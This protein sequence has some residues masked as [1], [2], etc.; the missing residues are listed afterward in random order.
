MI[1]VA[2]VAAVCIAV[3]VSYRIYDP[4]IWQN[5]VVG[6][7]I[8]QL[9]Q[10]P[11]TQLWSWPTFGAPDIKW[12]WGFSALVW[13]VWERWGV[14]GLFAWRWATA[15]A[16]FALLWA[17][18]RRMGAR[19]FTALWVMVVYSLTWR[20]RSQVRP[21]TL[22]AVLL[23]AQVW[24]LETR[25]QGGRDHTLWLIPVAWAWANVH[26]T[27]FL[28]F[29]VIGIFLLEDLVSRRR[30]P[31]APSARDRGVA[32]P[33][34]APASARGGAT[35]AGGAASGRT[36]GRWRLLWIG[37]AS[38]VISFVN[39]YGWR[40]LWEP[41]DFFLHHRNEPIFQTI[42]ELGPVQW[43]IYWKKGLPFLVAG[44]PL[45]A[46]WHARTRGADRVELLCCAAFTALALP[47]QR[48][49]GLYALVAAPYV[50]RDLEA[51]LASGARERPASPARAKPAPRAAPEPRGAQASRAE[52]TPSGAAAAPARVPWPMRAP[53]AV[54]AALTAL[55]CVAVGWAEWSR[56]EM[57]LGIGFLWNKYPVAACD[58]M[59]AHGVRGRGFNLFG[60]AGYQL[61]RFWPDRTRLP[62]I[63]I[64]QAGS[65]EDR[66]L[67]AWL[68]Q[69]EE[70]WRQLDRKYRF[71]YALIA[72][73]VFE[74]YTLLN[75]LDADST[76][77]L[78]FVDDVM[79]LYARR[80]G[81]LATLARD[82]AYRDVPGGANRLDKAG[83]AAER[84]TVLRARFHAEL[85][86]VIAES[87]EHA[88]ALVL[89]ANLAAAGGRYAEAKALLA[90][91][92]AVDPLREGAHLRLAVLALAEGEPREALKEVDRECEVADPNARQ[93]VVAGQ[94]WARLGDLG[95]ARAAY[96]R[97]LKRE[98]AN[99]EARDSL[100]ALGG[101]R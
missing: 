76:W 17:A 98:P 6:K 91:S 39:P 73:G 47:A 29:G 74:R 94:A 71:D 65:K 66:Y 85:E 46:L 86:R 101:G 100:A 62:F 57:P 7:A 14:W 27:Y 61:Y 48:F 26:N 50:G 19:G 45:L 53:L 99:A 40:L 92:L 12:T 43:D 31:R 64:H 95:R 18:A 63:D 1:A 15:L 77:A 3:S 24:I 69:S 28:G 97:A 8:W 25:R 16:A 87:P 2:V 20:A 32:A 51:W 81:P 49:L 58:F 60:F 35:P 84:D 5:L 79:A 96:R 90:R 44:W 13:P 88:Q 38:L 22:A 33:P 37:L 9:H 59:A 30:G 72:R 52:A 75:H 82:F 42:A 78:V 70:A 54:R 93:D 10:V 23:A 36:G 67:Y 83:A 89:E 41:F 21:E 68:Q 4:D 55:A 34:R 56:P 11:R 80:D